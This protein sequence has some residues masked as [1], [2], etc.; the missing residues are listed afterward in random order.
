M[1]SVVIK[2]IKCT[3]LV[4]RDVPD[5]AL[6]IEVARGLGA[7]KTTPRQTCWWDGPPRVQKAA[8]INT[9]VNRGAGRRHVG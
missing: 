1:T 7:L 2:R 8:V 5:T 3:G 9:Q 4:S 6:L